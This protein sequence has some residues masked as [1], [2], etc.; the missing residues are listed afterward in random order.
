M[1]AVLAINGCGYRCDAVT[2]IQVNDEYIE[3]LILA[4]ADGNGRSGWR[5]RSD[6]R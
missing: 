6:L 5:L 2:T 3:M 4:L 1:M